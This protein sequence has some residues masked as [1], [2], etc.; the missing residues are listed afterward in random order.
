MYSKPHSHLSRRNK[1]TDTMSKRY[2]DSMGAIGAISLRFQSHF[3]K[4]AFFFC[5]IKFDIFCHIWPIKPLFCQV[6]TLFWTKML[7]VFRKLCKNYL[8]M[9]FWQNYLL[10][11]C[12]FSSQNIIFYI[13]LFS[14]TLFELRI[15]YTAV[16]LVL[17]RAAVAG[18]WGKGGGG[19]GVAQGH[20]FLFWIRIKSDLFSCC[21]SNHL[22]LFQ[23][24]L[25]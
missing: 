2:L 5:H 18:G 3:N 7:H 22:A 21:I 19:G 10:L 4:S 25:C 11:F 23:A 13:K 16:W 6:R 15:N 12:C 8:V 17:Y 9:I 1:L 24:I 14:V 20:R